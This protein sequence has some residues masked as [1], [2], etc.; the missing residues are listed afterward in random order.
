MCHSDKY[1][2]PRTKA[3][4]GKRF[5]GFQTG[6]MVKAVVPTGKNKGVHTGTVAVRS[7]GKFAILFQKGKIDGINQKYCKRIH[8]QDGYVYSN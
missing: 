8:A 7:N 4:S 3:K 5:F 6:D 2:F 1:G